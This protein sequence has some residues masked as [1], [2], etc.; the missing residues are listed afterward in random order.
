MEMLGIGHCVLDH[1][2]MLRKYPQCDTKNDAV[3]SAI[4][5]GGPVPNACIV[6]SRLGVSVAYAGVCGA[7]PAGA[8]IKDELQS[9]GVVVENLHQLEDAES[10]R[11]SIW[12]ELEQGRRTV[13]L[14]RGTLPDLSTTDLDRLNFSDYQLL[15]LDG[16]EAICLEAAKRMQS[17]GGKVLLDLGG[18]RENPFELIKN[19]DY[20]IVSRSFV[21]D[22]FPDTDLFE[23]CNI[24]AAYGPELVVVTLGAGGC[25]VKQNDRPFWFPAY[26]QTKVVDTT[27]AGDVFHGTFAW[28]MLSEMTVIDS[29]K[30]AAIA[31]S[32]CCGQLGGHSGIPDVAELEEKLAGWNPL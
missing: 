29:L 5:T 17:A 10:A 13:S 19:T 31:S 20:L 15:L 28:G 6:A 4:S 7:D 21:M 12:V 25:M 9:A 30:A 26:T 23:V 16:K 27:G 11:A 3:G 2:I 18:H 8:E 24:L 1:F 32:A 22:Q 14:Y